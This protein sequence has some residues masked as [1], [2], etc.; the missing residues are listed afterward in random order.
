[1][2]PRAEPSSHPFI[3]P[4]QTTTGQPAWPPERTQEAACLSEE[5][6]PSHPRAFFLSAVLFYPA[7][8]RYV[9]PDVSFGCYSFV[10]PALACRRVYGAF[11]INM[12][13]WYNKNIDKYTKTAERWV[14]FVSKENRLFWLSTWVIILS[15]ANIVFRSVKPK[16]P[17]TTVVCVVSLFVACI[18]AVGV[19]VEIMRYCAS[20]TPGEESEESEET[21]KWRRRMEKCA[22]WA[23]AWTII[24]GIFYICDGCNVQNFVS[25]STTGRTVLHIVFRGAT[26]AAYAG[27]AISY[28]GYFVCLVMGCKEDPE[29]K[30][31][32][33]RN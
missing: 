21:E 29:E 25:V 12:Y 7:R 26:F 33:R 6:N 10:R 28:P 5:K 31:G 2:R 15:I 3:Q 18:A 4:I 30:Q 27:I 24:Y 8:L 16:S 32:K 19:I 17:A 13:M 22:F 20:N 11:A 9:F 1:M 14:S 23:I